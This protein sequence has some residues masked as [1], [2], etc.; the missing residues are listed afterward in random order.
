[1]KKIFLLMVALVAI[2]A[3]PAN[4]Q[5]KTFFISSQKVVSEI[6]T[7]KGVNYDSSVVIVY[8]SNEADSS[9]NLIVKYGKKK[10]PYFAYQVKK[11]PPHDA[12]VVQFII[13]A[14]ESDYIEL[15]VSSW[16]GTLG[17]DSDKSSMKIASK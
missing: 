11:V 8:Y 9:D 12:D 17:K 7:T 15:A 13:P 2:K 16:G 3:F 6:I 1:M 10:K 4:A 14:N 5:N